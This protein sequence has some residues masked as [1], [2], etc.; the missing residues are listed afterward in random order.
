MGRTIPTGAEAPLASTP[1]PDAPAAAAA[2][3]AAAAG[4]GGGSGGGGGGAAGPFT[5]DFF[6]QTRCISAEVKL[7]GDLTQTGVKA[8][9]HP[10]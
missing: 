8:L 5:F 7:S 10:L 2:A 1:A 3:A 6:E 9:H 4:G